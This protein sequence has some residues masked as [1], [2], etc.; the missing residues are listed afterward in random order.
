MKHSISLA[1]YREF[2][3]NGCKLKASFKVVLLVSGD[4]AVIKN[5]LLTEGNVC[6]V[7]QCFMKR[8]ALQCYPLSLSDINI[9][10]VSKVSPR[11]HIASWSDIDRKCVCMHL[12]DGHEYAVIPFAH[13]E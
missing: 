9:Y 1:Q 8:R 13:K 10:V 7:Y 6:F 3:G 11:L 5:I 2:N 4:I 12:T